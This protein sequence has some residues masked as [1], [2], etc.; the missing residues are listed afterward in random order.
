MAGIF[1]VRSTHCSLLRFFGKVPILNTQLKAT[2][3]SYNKK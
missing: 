1:F 3:I 2:L